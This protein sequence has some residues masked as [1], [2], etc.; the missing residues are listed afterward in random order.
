MTSSCTTS[1]RGQRVKTLRFTKLGYHVMQV[2]AC[3]LCGTIPLPEPVQ[4][5]SSIGN[6][7]TNLIEAWIKIQKIFLQRS[8]F[9]SVCKTSAI[10]FQ[11]QCVYIVCSTCIYIYI[12]LIIAELWSSYYTTAINLQGYIILSVHPSVWAVCEFLVAGYLFQLFS[13][14][15]E[16]CLTCSWNQYHRQD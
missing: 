1:P 4:I 13:D 6:V 8:A 12:V 11:P 2:M 10:L 14:F 15:Y 3:H 7:R 16:I 9:E 5:Y